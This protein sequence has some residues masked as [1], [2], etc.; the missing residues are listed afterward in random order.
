MKLPTLNVISDNKKGNVRLSVSIEGPG[1]SQQREKCLITVFAGIAIFLNNIDESFCKP[2][3]DLLENGGC[4][5][6]S[7]HH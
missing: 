5:L 3:T 7:Y 2:S 1:R 6:S 4:L